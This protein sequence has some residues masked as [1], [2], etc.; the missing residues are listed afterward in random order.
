MKL[1]RKLSKRHYNA[2]LR[3]PLQTYKIYLIHK[4]IAAHGGNRPNTMA[5]LSTFVPA[6]DSIAMTMGDRPGR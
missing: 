5:S 2:I 1:D 4:N 3:K 6:R